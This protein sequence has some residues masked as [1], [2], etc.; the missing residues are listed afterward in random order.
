MALTAWPFD[1]LHLGIVSDGMRS[2]AGRWTCWQGGS[3]AR[4][5]DAFLMM[6]GAVRSY[7]FLLLFVVMTIGSVVALHAAG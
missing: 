3:A 1:K 7:P 2:W 5:D 6:S 4:P